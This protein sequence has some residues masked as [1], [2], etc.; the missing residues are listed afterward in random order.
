MGVRCL[1]ALQRLDVLQAG[2]STLSALPGGLTTSRPAWRASICS[3]P[4]L[5]AQPEAHAHLNTSDLNK[6]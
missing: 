1:G 3:V 4:W 2:S 5:S 6:T